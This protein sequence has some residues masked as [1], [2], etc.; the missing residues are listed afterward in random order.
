MFV[1]A[2]LSDDSFVMCQTLSKK[3]NEEHIM[4]F[5]YA[6]SHEGT[7]EEWM[8]SHPCLSWSVLISTLLRAKEK[9]AAKFILQNHESQVKG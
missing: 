5:L 7:L 4:S 2:F 1:T 3:M 9:E 8:K 6:Q